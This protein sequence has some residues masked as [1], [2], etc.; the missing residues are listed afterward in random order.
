MDLYCLENVA[1]FWYLKAGKLRQPHEKVRGGASLAEDV[2]ILGGVPYA[3][4]PDKAEGLTSGLILDSLCQEQNI[5][6]TISI[7]IVGVYPWH[8]LHTIVMCLGSF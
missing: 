6:I 4:P 2:I 1:T 7:N 3:A 8:M 5:P